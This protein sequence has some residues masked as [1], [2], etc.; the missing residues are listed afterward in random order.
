MNTA[1]ALK[2]GISAEIYKYRSTFVFWFIILAPAFIPIINLIVFLKRGDEI[3]ERGGTAW[4]NLLQF[5][6]GPANFLFPF[7]VFIV[8][9][10]VSNIEWNSNTWK[11]IYTQPINRLSVFFSKLLVFV[12]MLFVSL[13][14]YGTL[15]LVVGKIVH[16][17]NPDLGFG[18]PFDLV[19]LYGRTFRMFLAT[20]GFASIQFYISQRTKNI[21]LP[22]GIGIGGIISFMIVVQ[23]W[24]Y[25]MFHPYGYHVAASGEYVGAR[26]LLLENMQPIY[27]SLA[28]FLIL[29][30]TAAID[31]SKKR[32]V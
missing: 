32:I 10:F 26:S 19:M 8:A 28:V 20:L 18:D 6:N 16:T 9:L 14:L 30:L 5:S 17:I 1:I 7:F 25:A 23:G 4:G 29:S 2:R 11:L 15:I 31:A 12:A 27:L 21:L 13:M 22:L 3:V 24:E